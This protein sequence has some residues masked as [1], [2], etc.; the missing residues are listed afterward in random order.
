MIDE[1][2]FA[3][4]TLL[5]VENDEK[6]RDKYTLTFNKLFKNVLIASDGSEALDKFNIANKNKEKIDVIISEVLLPHLDG[7]ELLTHIKKTNKNIPFIFTSTNTKIEHLIVSIKK[8]VSNYFVKPFDTLSILE[9]IKDSCSNNRSINKDSDYVNELEEYLNTINKVAI[10]SIFDNEGKIHYVNDFFLEVSKY[11][12]E[13]LLEQDY[14]FTYHT[15]ISNSILTNQWVDL[16]SSKKWKGKLK[17][18]AQNNSIF[19]TNTT[20]LP[21]VN[22]T[23]MER[24]KFISIDFLTTKEEN[25]KRNYKKKVL[26]N[27]QETKKVYKV[28]QNKIDEIKLEISKYGDVSKYE[29]DLEKE[30]VI[31]SKYYDEIKDFESKIATLDKKQNALTFGVNDKINKISNIITEMIEVEFKAKTKIKKVEEEIKI[32]EELIK[33]ISNEIQSQSMRIDDLKDVVKY[34]DKQIENKSSTLYD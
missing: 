15:D 6:T 30:K 25:E 33:K 13:D 23:D 24:K 2:F 31:S 27:L 21:V 9:Q 29:N 32:R 19:Y 12:E 20:I 14:K 16:Q 26:Y 8:G 34:R 7:I 10:V 18:I 4:L 5:Y 28:A 3:T 22:K 11:K 1:D 17:H